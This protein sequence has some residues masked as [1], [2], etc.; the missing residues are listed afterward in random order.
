MPGK[1]TTM[2]LCLT[3]RSV[4]RHIRV[5]SKAE[6]GERIDRYIDMCNES[7]RPPNWSYGISREPHPLAA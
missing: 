7:S 3:A 2:S 6:L 1:S 4:L 5:A